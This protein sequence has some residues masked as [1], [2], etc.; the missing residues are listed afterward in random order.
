MTAAR[1]C[2]IS[3]DYQYRSKSARLSQTEVWRIA[4]GSAVER[5]T[6]QRLAP[7]AGIF[8]A[9]GSQ[10]S[11]KRSARNGVTCQSRVQTSAIRFPLRFGLLAR[12]RADL[13]AYRAGAVLVLAFLLGLGA[14]ED[15]DLAQVLVFV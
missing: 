7:E 5:I 8:S 14:D 4:R 12:S 9:A 3:S 6:D 10:R 13:R 1:A 2:S 11:R 15:R